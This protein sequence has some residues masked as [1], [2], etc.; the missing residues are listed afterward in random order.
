[1]TT[2]NLTDRQSAALAHELN[3]FN[4]ANPDAAAK[5]VDDFLQMLV[6]ARAD[7]AV[8]QYSVITPFA[9]VQRFTPQEYAGIR[10]AG[11]TN[12]DV[13]GYLDALAAANTV[14]LTHEKVADGLALLEQAGLIATGRAA[15]IGSL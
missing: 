5:G 14:D 11:T 13:Q 3:D 10:K 9:F 6:S 7:A 1:M 4:K 2:V 15:Q 12:P 8:R